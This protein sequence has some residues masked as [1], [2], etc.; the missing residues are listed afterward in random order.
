MADVPCS[1]LVGPPVNF[2]DIVHREIARVRGVDVT[3]LSFA[4]ELRE[5]RRFPASH[6][7]RGAAYEARCAMWEAMT[8]EQVWWPNPPPDGWS[9]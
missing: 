5:D 4:A 9:G 3:E 7:S 2:R 8:A 6:A 1:V